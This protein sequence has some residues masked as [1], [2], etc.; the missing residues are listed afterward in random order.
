MTD[1]IV[2]RLREDAAYMDEVP[3]AFVGNPYYIAR[4]QREAADEIEQLRD[5]V[6]DLETSI[7]N[8]AEMAG[9]LQGLAKAVRATQKKV[10]SHV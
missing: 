1:D 8:E 6:T 5:R 9:D 7:F 4:N 2:E 3:T 10:A